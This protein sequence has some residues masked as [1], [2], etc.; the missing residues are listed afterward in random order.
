MVGD[1]CTLRKANTEDGR[2]QKLDAAFTHASTSY[3]AMTI[4]R[5]IAFN[6]LHNG[7]K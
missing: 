4:A 1:Q 5:H 7:R 2:F 6:L 3:G